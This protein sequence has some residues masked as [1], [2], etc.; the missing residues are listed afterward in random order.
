M[1]LRTRKMLGYAAALVVLLAVFML[2][3]RPETM[4]SLAEQLW[5]CF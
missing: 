3:A 5:A 1:Q 4:V 2:Y